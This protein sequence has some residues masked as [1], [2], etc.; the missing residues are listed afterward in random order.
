VALSQGRRKRGAHALAVIGNWEIDA[1]ARHSLTLK[2]ITYT[3]LISDFWTACIRSQQLFSSRVVRI[4]ESTSY[5]TLNASVGF[6]PEARCAGINAAA[7]PAEQRTRIVL[8]ITAG[9]EGFTS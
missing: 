9:S 6:T 5:S 3:R 8:A 7:S 1:N 4:S 2:L